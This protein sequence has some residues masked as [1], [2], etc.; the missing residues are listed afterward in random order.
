MKKYIC[1]MLILLVGGLAFATPPVTESISGLL[2]KNPR[3]MGMGGAFRV[4]STGYD[5]FFGNPAGFAAK[6]GSL[7]FADVATWAYFKP[8]VANLDKVQAIM[9]NTATTGEVASYVSDWVI[10]NGL[11][12]GVSAGLGWAGKGFG[13]GFNLVTDNIASGSSL[14]SSTFTSTTQGNVVAGLGLPL[15]LGPV[16]IKLGADARAFYILDSVSGSGY[17]WPFATI[18]A[19]MAGGGDPM[20]AI[21]D[22]TVLGGYGF[23]VDAGLTVG[24]GPFMLGGMVRDYGFEFNMGT[25]TVGNV[26]DTTMVPVDGTLPHILTPT[27]AVGAG[28]AF[29][30]GIIAPSLY[31][32]AEDPVALVEQGFDGI[33][34]KVHA[35]AELELLQFIKLRA[36]LNKGWVSVGAGLD[37]IIFEFDA[38]L[39]TEEMGTSP[40]DFGRTGI[41]LQAA[42]RF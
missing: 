1:I 34:N 30:F 18:L 23:A 28:L 16:K 35:G 9:D 37:L 7:T 6:N 10:N 40:G 12:V 32:E 31:V 17:N 41:A 27:F 29:D 15:N 19:S 24:I 5:T 36:G 39:F 26:L 11:G 38:A 22:M 25:D 4:F 2:P 3:A 14:L 21:R 8:T 33:W 13:L 20:T 42:F